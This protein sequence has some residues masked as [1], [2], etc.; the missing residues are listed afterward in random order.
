MSTKTYYPSKSKVTGT[1]L[2]KAIFR[3]F[4]WQGRIMPAFWT[5]TSIFSLVINVVLVVLL[6][7][8]G[9]QLFTLKQAISVQLVNG[10]HENFKDMNEAVIDET[11]VVD[12][13]IPV[14][15]DIPVSTNTRVTLTEPTQ[16][17][18]AQVAIRSGVINLNAP[19]NIVLPAGTSLPIA[20]DI[21]VH[22]EETVPVHLEVPV[23]IEL[24]KTGLGSPFNGLIDVVSP[25]DSLLMSMDDSWEDTKLCQGQLNYFCE[26]FLFSK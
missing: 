25:Y 16:I 22:V 12:D 17:I 21:S 6:I 8:L 19:A 23:Y 10:L 3:R 2:A 26:W 24:S 7:S 5:V 11:I 15:F 14:Q 1:L 9:Q 4:I 13:T 18:G 20:L